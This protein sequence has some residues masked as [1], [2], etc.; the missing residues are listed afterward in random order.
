MLLCIYKRQIE[1]FEFLVFDLGVHLRSSIA[2]SKC[3]GGSKELNAPPILFCLVCALLNP[4]EK[5]SQNMFKELW[6]KHDYIWDYSCLKNA[7]I[8]I[9]IFRRDDLFD[10]IIRSKTTQSIFQSFSDLFKIEFIKKI[11][12]KYLKP[13]QNEDSSLQK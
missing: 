3:N 11:L 13:T 2:I 6:G 12:L 10:F 7:L 8:M 1:I 9:V 5:I 4:E